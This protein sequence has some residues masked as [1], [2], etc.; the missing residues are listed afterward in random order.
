MWQ[1]GKNRILY[2]N[3]FGTP[4]SV[5]PKYGNESAALVYWWLDPVRAAALE[6]ARQTDTALPPQPAEVH[7]AE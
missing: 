7:F 2:W 4:P 6:Q 3:K 1:S 5:L